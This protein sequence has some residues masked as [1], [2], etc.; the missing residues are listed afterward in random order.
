MV[1]CKDEHLAARTV[2]R[3]LAERG[4][5]ASVLFPR[6]VEL[7]PPETV[8]PGR[9]PVT[10]ETLLT[11]G[12]DGKSHPVTYVSVEAK[13]YYNCN[14]CGFWVEDWKR[15]ELRTGHAPIARLFCDDCLFYML[16]LVG[17]SHVD[18]FALQVAEIEFEPEMTFQAAAQGRS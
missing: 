6:Q 18:T 17:V 4:E 9:H 8:V 10:G 3:L 5:R 13:R 12:A 11:K 16:L 1:L 14:L 15:D 7:Y 2:S